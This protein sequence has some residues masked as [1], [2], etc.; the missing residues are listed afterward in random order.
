MLLLD[1]GKVRVEYEGSDAKLYVYKDGR[2]VGCELITECILHLLDE[3]PSEE[4][5]K[6]EYDSKRLLN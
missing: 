2:L 5:R 1:T 6:T 3:S 4:Y